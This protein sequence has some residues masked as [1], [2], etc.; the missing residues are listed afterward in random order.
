M[1]N[2]NRF[3]GD[4]MVNKKHI[5]SFYDYFDEVAEILYH[6]YQKAYIEGMNEA[7]NFLL[8]EEFEGDYSQE[9]IEKISTLKENLEKTKFEREEVRKAVQLGMLKGYKHT[10]SSNSLRRSPSPTTSCKFLVIRSNFSSGVI[11]ISINL[12]SFINH[13]IKLLKQYFKYLI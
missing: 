2:Y 6:N 10:F 3:C 9:D 11:I 1:L 13:V 8:D 4:K 5:E 12:Y 7:F